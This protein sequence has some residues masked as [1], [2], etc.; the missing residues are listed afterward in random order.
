MNEKEINN[1]YKDLESMDSKTLLKL[2]SEATT[3]IIDRHFNEDHKEIQI[4]AFN[5]SVDTNN[6]TIK[7]ALKSFNTQDNS[8]KYNGDIEAFKHSVLDTEI[9]ISKVANADII[10]LALAALVSEEDMMK[11]ISAYEQKSAVFREIF[12][13]WSI[14]LEKILGGI[15]GLPYYRFKEQVSPT[16]NL[17]MQKLV[18]CTDE[19]CAKSTILEDLFLFFDGSIDSDILSSYLLATARVEVR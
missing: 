3:L 17:S 19:F 18:D 4:K 9:D 14:K 8:L 5:I 11:L 2:I 1:M 15:Y 12:M 13:E 7:F 10:Q 6:G 16:K